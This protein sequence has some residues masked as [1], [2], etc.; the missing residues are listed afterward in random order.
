M[1]TTVGH[2]ESHLVRVCWYSI[3]VILS[4]VERARFPTLG[5][6]YPLI[7]EHSFLS[8][9]PRNLNRTLPSY[10][11]DWILACYSQ[12]LIE[13][14]RNCTIIRLGKKIDFYPFRNENKQLDINVLSIKAYFIHKQSTKHSKLYEQYNQLINVC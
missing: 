1:C 4:G 5:E 6:I 2:V 8:D 9:T 10:E 11:K 7:H 13:R 3:Q 14:C 12:C